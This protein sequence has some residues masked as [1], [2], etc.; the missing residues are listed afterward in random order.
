[1]QNIK[2]YVLGRCFGPAE[3]QLVLIEIARVHVC[4]ALRIV[5]GQLCQCACAVCVCVCVCR[6]GGAMRLFGLLIS[7]S[8]CPLL[9]QQQQQQQSAVCS[10]EEG[11]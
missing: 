6:L 1:M 10:L 2:Y 3:K 4:F 9:L 5:K 7:V 8:G 11:G